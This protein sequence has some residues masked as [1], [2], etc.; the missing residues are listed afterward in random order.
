M[1]NRE[2]RVEAAIQRQ[3]PE[4]RMGLDDPCGPAQ[5]RKS[6][7]GSKRTPGGWDA[8]MLPQQITQG[9]GLGLPAHQVRGP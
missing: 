8:V 3:V 7:E 9:G 5:R 4:E 2:A 6:E 1:D